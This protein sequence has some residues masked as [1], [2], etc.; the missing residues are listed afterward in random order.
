MTS[1]LQTIP[2][3][4]IHNTSYRNKNNPKIYLEAQRTQDSQRN[5]KKN[6][7]KRTVIKDLA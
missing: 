4:Y 6:K 1:I 5:P 2:S 3:K 7:C